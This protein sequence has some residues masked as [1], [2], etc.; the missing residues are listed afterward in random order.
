MRVEL[1]LTVLPLF[2]PTSEPTPSDVVA[3]VLSQLVPVEE[4]V[5]SEGEGVA[6]LANPELSQ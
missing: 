1:P 5:Q 3:G 6:T 2:E 4:I